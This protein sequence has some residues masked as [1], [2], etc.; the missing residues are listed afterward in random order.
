MKIKSTNAMLSASMLSDDRFVKQL[1]QDIIKHNSS[2]QFFTVVFTKKD[3]TERRM[4]ARMGVKKHL[5]GGSKGYEYNHL[6]GV[7][8]SAAMG[9][10]TI[11][12]RTL[13][14]ITMRGKTTVF[15]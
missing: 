14:R 12:L 8:D 5:K 6:L 4:T 13:K 11:N 15:K 10:R 2:G 1:K 3:G 9:Y 7:W